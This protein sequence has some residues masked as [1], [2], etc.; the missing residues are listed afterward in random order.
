MRHASGA[1]N[2]CNMFAKVGSV[3][4]VPDCLRLSKK[5]L[6]PEHGERGL[7]LCTTFVGISVADSRKVTEVQKL[8]HEASP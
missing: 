4:G 7:H 6:M 8:V 3:G 2:L 5:L 1:R